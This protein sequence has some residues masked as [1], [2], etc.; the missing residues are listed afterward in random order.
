MDKSIY[1]LLLKK[2]TK[3]AASFDLY[4]LIPRGD[5]TAGFCE[6]VFEFNVYTVLDILE[7]D[8][9][10]CEYMYFRTILHAYRARK[11]GKD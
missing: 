11:G 1:D 6:K 9:I 8:I 2:A 4:P 5:L 3:L 10:L 7:S